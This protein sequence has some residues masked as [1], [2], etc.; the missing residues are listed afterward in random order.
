M[1]DWN[2]VRNIALSLPNTT[3]RD[4]SGVPQWRVNDKLFVWERPLRKSDFAALGDDAPSDPIIGIRVE[5][6]GA[7]AALIADEPDVFFTTP[8]FDGYP[9]VLAQLDRIEL[10]ELQEL[11][12]EAWLLRAP[13]RLAKKYLDAG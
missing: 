4:A 2:D 5:D 12:V 13:K 7:K 9:I 8:H 6:E 1:A 10:A 11:L 3:E